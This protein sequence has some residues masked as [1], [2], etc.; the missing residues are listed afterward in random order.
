[1][2]TPK[3]LFE[4]VLDEATDDLRSLFHDDPYVLNM[5]SDMEN[6]VQPVYN[7]IIKEVET[8]FETNKSLD[9][10]EYAILAQKEQPKLMGLL[11]LAYLNRPIDYKEFSKKNMKE[12][13][14]ISG[15]IPM[16]MTFE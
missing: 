9:R 14:G 3:R 13:F 10:K 6:R 15:E 11:M 12:I 8:F 4:C 1:V 5:I 7:H 16:T 2:Y